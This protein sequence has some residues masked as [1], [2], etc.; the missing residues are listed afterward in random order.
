MSPYR[1]ERILHHNA[2]LSRRIL[3][4]HLNNIAKLKNFK[5]FT[6]NMPKEKGLQIFSHPY[7][8]NVPLIFVTTPQKLLMNLLNILLNLGRGFVK[9][10]KEF[11]QTS[12]NRFNQS[13]STSKIQF[14]PFHFASLKLNLSTKNFHGLIQRGLIP[15]GIPRYKTS[16][17]GT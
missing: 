15:I 8:M 9:R 16:S 13:N 2:S 4:F 1:T 5:F 10:E 17:R 7:L 11:W 14:F 3:H 12:Q 6:P